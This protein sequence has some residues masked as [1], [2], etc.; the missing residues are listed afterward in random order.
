MNITI[1]KES[2]DRKWGS[3]YFYDIYSPSNTL[4]ARIDGGHFDCKSPKTTINREITEDGFTCDFTDGDFSKKFYL[5]P[6]QK[7][8]LD[9]LLAEDKPA[10]IWRYNDLFNEDLNKSFAS[11]EEAIKY[12]QSIHPKDRWIHKRVFEVLSTL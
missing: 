12:G 7:E 1:K 10:L 11:K 8:E 5:N 3:V 9:R 4:I 6:S 2:R